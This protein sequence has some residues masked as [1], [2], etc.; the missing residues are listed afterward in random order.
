MN[1][2]LLSLLAGVAIAV[3]IAL[4]YRLAPHPKTSVS[5][6]TAGAA[7]TSS[8][9]ATQDEGDPLPP[10]LHLADLKGVNHPFTQWRGKLLLLNFWATWCAPCRAEIPL[11]IQ[12]QQ[13]YAARGLQIVGP[14]VDDPGL[15]AG[16]L[17]RLGLDYPVLVGDPD[18]L[19]KIMD[20]LGNGPGG[21]PFSVLISP[22]GMILERRVGAFDKDNLDQLIRAHLPS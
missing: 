1:R 13:Q 21:L 18:T 20:Q 19:V 17:P 22:K 11:L 12:M 10:G 6:P 7:A 5:S 14:A 2:S 15:V 3:G 8:A 4:L 16:A 9:G